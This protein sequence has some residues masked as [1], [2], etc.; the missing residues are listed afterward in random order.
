MIQANGSGYLDREI[1]FEMLL[2][3]LEGLLE[4]QAERRGEETLGRT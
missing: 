1:M 3:S 4:K 2:D